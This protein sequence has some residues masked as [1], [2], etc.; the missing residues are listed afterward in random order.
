M[1]QA[2]QSSK[3]MLKEDDDKDDE[4]REVKQAVLVCE[5]SRKAGKNLPR[6]RGEPE[7]CQASGAP[8]F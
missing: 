8:S 3:Q 1:E 6:S 4:D 2:I 7:K 5:H